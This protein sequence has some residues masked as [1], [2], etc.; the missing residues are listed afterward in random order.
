MT[1]PIAKT[2]RQEFLATIDTMGEGVQRWEPRTLGDADKVAHLIARSNLCPEGLKG[3]P[4]DVLLV[5]IQGQELGLTTMQSLQCLHVIKGKVGLSADLMQAL[6][7]RS[8]LAEHFTLIA[9]D[10]AS[11]TYATMRKGS[12]REVSL[13][14][15]IE[16]ARKAGLS[17]AN[18][19]NHPA[20]MLR[21]RCKCKLAR[22][23]YPD[24]LAGFYAPE[25]LREGRVVDA[26]MVPENETPYDQLARAITPEEAA[27]DIEEIFGPAQTKEEELIAV[28]AEHGLSVADLERRLGGP[29]DGAPVEELE[30]IVHAVVAAN[31]PR[32]A[33]LL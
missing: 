3:K 9:S 8:G 26:E 5:L 11:A 22:A 33:S 15:T 27:A 14:Y 18:W 25:E 6:V 23:V 29:V 12:P 4:T 7:M 28:A 32:Q 24:V 13:S 1:E 2:E 17:G 10:E 31:D 19:Q 30:R 16:Q 21:A 20:D